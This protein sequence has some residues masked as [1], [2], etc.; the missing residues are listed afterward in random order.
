MSFLL[1]ARARGIKKSCGCGVCLR[2]DED[3]IK[4]I[5]A[6]SQALIVPYYFA[7]VNRSRGKK[8]GDQ[9]RQEDHWK[10]I[11]AKQGARKRNDHPSILTRWQNDEQYRTSQ[12]SIGLTET[13]CW[14]LD[15]LTTVDISH[16]APYRQRS[17]YESTITMKSRDR[18]G[19][20]RTAEQLQKHC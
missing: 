14:Y 6:R 7:R 15:Y 11:D 5:K 16:H 20:E 2:P 3:T 9:Q 1:E 12:L 4:S 18:C 17:R 13:C 10:A 8:Y 19:K